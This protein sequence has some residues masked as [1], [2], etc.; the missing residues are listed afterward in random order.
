MDHG[1]HTAAA[2]R[3]LEAPRRAGR[4]AAALRCAPQSSPALGAG[5]VFRRICLFCFI[6]IWT[7]TSMNVL[8]RRS[9]VQSLHLE[10]SGSD[11]AVALGAAPRA[12]PALVAALKD[13]ERGATP[14]RADTLKLPFEAAQ[15]PC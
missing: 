8:R 9:D 7:S 13:Q 5:V 10:G 15:L 14:F 6:E 4:A 12:L 1:L 11:P 3:F 2:S